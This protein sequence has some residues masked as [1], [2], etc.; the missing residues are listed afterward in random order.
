MTTPEVY[1]ISCVVVCGTDAAA[2]RATV[3]SVLDQTLAGTEAV[4]VT[5]GADETA[6]SLAAGDPHRIRLVHAGAASPA[7]VLRDLGLAAA[8]GRYVMVAAPGERLERHACRNLFEAG[9]RTDADLVAG[10]WDKAPAWQR[11]L[12]ARSRVVEDLADAP[13]LVTRDSLSAGFCVRRC[14]LGA[15]SG[16]GRAPLGV[17][18]ALAARR[19][20]LVPNLITSGCAPADP[21]RDLPRAADAQRGTLELLDGDA[22]RAARESAFL[23]D[24]V[25]PCV[26]A[27]L[28]LGPEDRRETADSLAP[29]L[30]GLVTPD[31]LRALPPVER[32]GVRLLVDGD[33]DGVQAAAYALARPGTVVSPLVMTGGGRVRWSAEHAD[34]DMFDVTE[35]GHQYRQFTDLRLLNRVTHCLRQGAVL[36]VEGRLV[37]PL[38]LLDDRPALA[39]RL[40]L[41]VRGGRAHT[42]SVPVADVRQEDGGVVWR[43]ELPLTGALRPRGIGDRVWD[44]RL[45]LTV[46][47]VPVTT[48]LVADKAAVPTRA[49]TLP[50]RPR[51]TRLTADTWQPYV[52]AKHHLA[53]CLLPRRRAARTAQAVLHYVTHFR[54]ARKLKPVLRALN[55]KREALHSQRVKLRVYRRILARLPVSKGLVVFES[56]MGKSYG[57]SPRAVHE[58]LLARGARVRCVWSYATSS[59]GFPADSR[60]VRRWSWRYLWA[61]ARAEW[62]VDNQGFPHALDKPRHTTYLQ[63]WH[64]SA[65]KRMGFDE[66]RHRTRNAPEREKLRRAVGRFDHFMVRSEH[67]VRTLARAYRIP[68]ERLLRA[69]YPRNDRLVEARGRDEREGRFPRPALATELGIPDHRTVVLYAPT[70]RGVPKSGRI[71]QL[72]LDV[73]EF[74]HRFGDT[75]VLLVR[76]HYMEAANLPVTP[77]GT[78]IDVSGHH[79]V[80]ELLVLADVLITDYS[81]IMFDYALLDRPLMHFAPDLDAYAADRGAYFDLRKRAGGPVVETQEELLRTLGGLKKADGEW[82]AAR[83]AFAAE[84]GSYD[85]GGAARAAADLILGKKARA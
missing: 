40:D 48:D 7:C 18:A 4:L 15:L 83:R 51:L 37:V 45:V 42:L 74:A 28:A 55:K 75:H 69:G 77:P 16:A 68:E 1:D 44:P 32:I 54:P 27:F 10:R 49:T 57:D 24:H 64:G 29:S 66:A 13:E 71:V 47:G 79:D 35:L 20:A 63:T 67:D 41:S 9:R 61:L 84:F 39:A 43:T 19:I 2:L 46:D 3:R 30:Q 52:T 6:A 26:R 59:A 70:F 33:A 34:D 56:H 23:A 22:L 53:V 80:S 17:R 60:L 78:V 81:S 82:Q 21:V 11:E 50:A 58:E 14:A 62:W 65:Y 76:A 31:A 25:I 38:G 5:A 12:H 36:A 72:P 73:R 8:R 85:D